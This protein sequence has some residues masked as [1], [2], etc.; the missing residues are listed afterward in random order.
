MSDADLDAA[1]L[2]AHEL[3]DTTHLI[4]LY[5]KAADRHEQTDDLDAACFFLTQA[6]VFALE[7]G[8]E[9]ADALHQRLINHQRV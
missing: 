6:Y 3:G 5:T 8:D 2:H 7:D 1:I 4:A 9:R